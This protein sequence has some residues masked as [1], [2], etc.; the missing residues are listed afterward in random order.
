MLL[1]LLLGY[2][3]DIVCL[4]EVDQKFYIGSLSGI[5]ES[6]GYGGLFNSKPGEVAEGTATFYKK[7]RFR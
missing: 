2:N 6:Q 5:M 1:I 4:Q 3:A 7:D